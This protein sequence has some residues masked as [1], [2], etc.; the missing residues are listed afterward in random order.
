MP[1]LPSILHRSLYAVLAGVALVACGDATL[2]VVLGPD[3]G[4]NSLNPDGGLA[5]ID[6]GP[7]I[8]LVDGS[9]VFPDGAVVAGFCESSGPLVKLPQGTCTG[10]LGKRTFLFAACSCEDTEVSG[11][12]RT[13]SV[14]SLGTATSGKTASMGANGAFRSNAAIDLGGSIWASTGAPAVSLT[15]HGTIATE[16]RSGSSLEVNGTF[17]VGG[18]VYATGGIKLD[19]GSLTCGGTLHVGS[20]TSTTGVTATGGIVTDAGPVVPPCNCAKP[21]D[22]GG[23]VQ[24]FATANDDKVLGI[25]RTILSASTAHNLTLACG[26]YYFDGMAGDVSLKLLGRTAIF[27]GGDVDVGSL[28]LNLDPDAEVD[29]FVAGGLGLNGTFS[30]NSA[31]AKVRVYIGGTNVTISGFV[32]LNGNVYAPNAV[33]LMS[34][35]F[36]MTGSLLAKQL[37]FSGDFTIHYDEAILDTQGCDL[38]GQ[39]C[40]SCHDCEG[41]TPACKGGTCVACQVND[42]CCAPLVCRSGKCVVD[43]R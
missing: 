22:I 24:S 19:T 11:A 17:Q 33:M 5:E 15:D 10:D 1:R 29:L 9:I 43:I 39:T 26:R 25:D 16:I 8:S 13:D 14:N 2:R 35:T 18:D 3:P 21:L 4:P 27:I 42:D 7:G 40:T 38:P 30:S 36:E 23:I 37:Q 41:T 12:L 28:K 20:G 32:G 34:S 6:S 31:A